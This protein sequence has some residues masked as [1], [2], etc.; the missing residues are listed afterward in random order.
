MTKF[1]VTRRSLLGASA[2][3]ALALLAKPNLAK[4][5]SYATQPVRLFVGTAAA[6]TVDL[7]A[8][9]LSPTFRDMLGQP[10][11]VE[12]RPGAATTLAAGLVANAKPDGHTLLVSSSAALAVHVA[13]ATK[14]THLINDLTHVGMACDGGFIYAIHK[15][16]PAKNYT[17]FVALLQQQPGKFRY[18]ATGIGGNIHLSG[19]L[20]CLNTGTRMVAVQYA[21]AG[22]RA[23]ELL[24]N[25]TQLGIGGGAV[26]GQHIRSGMLNGLF[27]ASEK[28]DA[29]F[30]D[31]PTSVELG[32]PGMQ[33]ITNW[34]ALH[35]PK[36]M[37]AE[38][39]QQLSQ[40]LQ[41]ALA[42]PEVVSGLA[43]SGLFTTPGTP[44]AL[45]ERM[46]VDYA[47]MADV[48]KRG[49]IRID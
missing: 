2:G 42:K 14:P 9:L 15:D 44:E 25:Q 32:I 43:A 29:L 30:P 45:I 8:R 36:G 11:L 23:N 37:P 24:S 33:N 20:F 19:A 10:V 17:E 13:S 40:V 39:V 35:G 34:V 48:A 5:A 46:K 16:V 41:V 7:V 31:L 49:D 38:I 21:N 47:V 26:L 4:A 1:T 18:G 12:N 22:M 3:G 6:G 27:V 28:R